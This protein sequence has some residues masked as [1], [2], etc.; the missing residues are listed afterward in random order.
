MLESG[1]LLNHV[2]G[3]G[4]LAEVAATI[5]ELVARQPEQICEVKVAPDDYEALAELIAAAMPEG[6]VTLISDPAL[7][8]GR[9]LE[10]Y[11]TTR[12]RVTCE[13]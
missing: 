5:V 1:Q 4:F 11:Q 3:A 7:A 2:I 13:G 10:R 6:P 9:L 12:N 8:T